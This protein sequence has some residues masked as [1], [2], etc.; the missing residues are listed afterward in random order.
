MSAL[1]TVTRN[2]Y[3]NLHKTFQILIMCAGTDAAAASQT[4]I[5]ILAGTA[6]CWGREA[7]QNSCLWLRWLAVAGVRRQVVQG[8]EG[9][10]VV[11]AAQADSLQEVWVRG[12]EVSSGTSQH[13]QVPGTRVRM[14]TKQLS[15]N[16]YLREEGC[17]QF[18]RNQTSKYW[19]GCSW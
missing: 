12:A 15:N 17:R 3:I 1:E 14:I 13:W 9:G 7:S 19:Q 5:S 10:K 18:P 16:L 11:P 8:V 6:A 2:I 4:N